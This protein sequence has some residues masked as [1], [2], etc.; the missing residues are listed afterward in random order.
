MNSDRKKAP[1]L[2]QKILRDIEMRIM[3]GEWAPGYRLPYE[4]ELAK[5]Y[6]V[7]RMTVNKVM[8]Q[9]VQAGLIERFKK[10]GSFVAQPR[11]H[12]AM[13][14][15]Q[16]IGQEVEKLGNTY[17]FSVVSRQVC[18]TPMSRDSID[19]KMEGAPYLDVSCLHEANGAPFCLEE[20][21]ISL[22]AV[23]EAANQLFVD[24]SPGTWLLQRVPWTSAEHNI[25]AVGA[26]QATAEKL[27]LENGSCCLVVQRRTW[28]DQGPVTIVRLTYPCDNHVVTARFQPSSS[29]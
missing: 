17:S 5:T 3:S 12:S 27:G 20:R 10:S 8:T 7:S 4:V 14:E 9:L 28:N 21:L 1:T 22:D 26:N 13:L 25:F 24:V 29:H 2:H 23:P 18:Q 19:D 16:D 15:I 6:K 11:E